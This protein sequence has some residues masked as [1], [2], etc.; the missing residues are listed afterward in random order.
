MGDY[1]GREGKRSRLLARSKDGEGEIERFQE[2]DWS[3]GDLASA[4]FLE[5]GCIMPGAKLLLRRP[6]APV[7][8]KRAHSRQRE[9]KARPHAPFIGDAGLAT[10]RRFIDTAALEGVVVA[11]AHTALFC[12]PLATRA[13]PGIALPTRAPYPRSNPPPQPY[14]Q[15]PTKPRASRP[16]F[17][18]KRLHPLATSQRT[19]PT[20]SR[21]GPVTSTSHKPRDPMRNDV[22][23]Q[24]ATLGQAPPRLLL[25][26]VRAQ[27]CSLALSVAM[28]TALFPPLQTPLPS[29]RRPVRLA[30]S[31]SSPFKCAPTFSSPSTGAWIPL[32]RCNF[33]LRASLLHKSTR[34][35][36]SKPQESATY[37]FERLASRCPCAGFAFHEHVLKS[38]RSTMKRKAGVQQCEG[39]VCYPT[40]EKRGKNLKR[41]LEITLKTAYHFTERPSAEWEGG[42]R[43]KN[44][45][46][47]VPAEDVP[48]QQLQ[49]QPATPAN[50]QVNAI[51]DTRRLA[52]V[53]P[54]TRPSKYRALRSAE[55]QRR[56]GGTRRLAIVPLWRCERS[57]PSSPLIILPFFA[58]QKQ[59]VFQHTAI[60]AAAQCSR[61]D[62]LGRCGQPTAQPALSSPQ[63]HPF[64]SFAHMV[65][66][67]GV[68]VPD[69]RASAN[70]PPPPAYLHEEASFFC[71]GVRAHVIGRAF[72][73]KA[74]LP[75]ARTTRATEQAAGPTPG[76]RAGRRGGGVA[77]SLR[78]PPHT[79]DDNNCHK[80]LGYLSAAQRGTRGGRSSHAPSWFAQA[81]HCARQASAPQPTVVCPSG[82][83]NDF[84]GGGTR[85][86]GN[87]R[88]GAN[89]QKLA[90][91]PIPV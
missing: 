13:F 80:P 44:E 26:L 58:R 35:E 12:A 59:F 9:Q 75:W 53:A 76:P 38:A 4:R 30:R 90:H 34:K 17:K 29:C 69:E 8:T 81:F 1:V 45:E 83:N 14:T 89:V 3:V 40:P 70:A 16:A 5:K 20:L 18:Q 71:G 84:A 41:K 61:L 25:S 7:E 51:K 63:M 72:N 10:A 11:V 32:I 62:K 21:K 85:A 86:M 79:S 46:T 24:G 82:A 64:S 48:K 66:A 67:R 56:S 68:T 2:R 50:G 22:T 65:K 27:G 73:T 36:K 91:P 43:K 60:R 78:T 31:S 15:S 33:L 47:R 55:E 23:V 39:P 88:N 6:T 28:A 49:Q 42:G 87:H 37:T 77:N 52:R 74:P 57:R 54:P 19:D